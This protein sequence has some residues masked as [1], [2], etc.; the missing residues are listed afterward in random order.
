MV[1]RRY[2]TPLFPMPCRI[3]P[4]P[5]PSEN[6]WTRLPDDSLACACGNRTAGGSAP[7]SPDSQA[8]ALRRIVQAVMAEVPVRRQFVS[9]R[10]GWTVQHA[11]SESGLWL[12]SAF[13]EMRLLRLGAAELPNP[14]QLAAASEKQL[15]DWLARSDLVPWGPTRRT[16]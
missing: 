10:V 15:Q 5:G 16:P 14:K 4:R 9:G 7:S 12:V 11:Q 8:A 1:S 6:L 13:G 3:A 2:R